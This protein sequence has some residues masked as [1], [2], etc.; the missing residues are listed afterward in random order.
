[1]YVL[2]V[3]MY[4]CEYVYMYIMYIWID[5]YIRDQISYFMLYCC[6]LKDNNVVS[7]RL[8]QRP[9]FF[10]LETKVITG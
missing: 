6:F 1:M 5:T 7:I 10:G 3:C 4:V 2:Y 8:Y 9:H